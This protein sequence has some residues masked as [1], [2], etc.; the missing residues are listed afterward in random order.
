MSDATGED[1]AASSPT[2]DELA[3]A[4]FFGVSDQPV[5]LVDGRWEGAPFVEGGASRP[6]VGLVEDFLLTGDLT[7]DG[8]EAAVVL[9][10]GS[11][12]GSGTRTYLAVA[13][14]QKG[15]VVNL[16]TTL[17]GDRVQVK[18]GFV[19]DALITL[20]LIQ[21][22]PGE[23]AC[24]PTQKVIAGWRLEDGTLVR[25]ATE[26]TG[27]L[28]LDDLQGPD[29][30]LDKIGWDEPVADLPPIWIHFEPGRVDGSGGCNTYFGTATGETPGELAFSAM[31]TTMMACSESVMELE[32]RYLRTLAGAESY[33]FLGGRLILG[34]ETD[35]GSVSL[36]FKRRSENPPVLDDGP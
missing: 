27:T 36:I 24:C 22:G 10:W 7:G 13:E 12:G 31:G 17:V 25:T 19:A 32:R 6:T 29:W 15:E 33:S 21:A 28:S 16:A 5:T 20:D 9:I 26:I 18:A 34:C 35:N 30:V 4:T 8:R 2:L 11:S 23:A 14:R 1:D 3:S